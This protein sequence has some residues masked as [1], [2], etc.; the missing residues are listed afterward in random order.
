MKKDVSDRHEIKVL[1]EVWFGLQAPN[2]VP[3]DHKGTLTT[4]LHLGDIFR[5]GWLQLEYF[6]V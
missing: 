3:D 4:P 2:E 5:G 1:G 6:S